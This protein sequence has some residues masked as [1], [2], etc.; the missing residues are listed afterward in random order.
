M[1]TEYMML[2][3]LYHTQTAAI[4]AWMDAPQD[5]YDDVIRQSIHWELDY[6]GLVPDAVTMFLGRNPEVGAEFLR[7]RY[8]AM[9]E[10]AYDTEECQGTR[11]FGVVVLYEEDEQDWEDE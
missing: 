8:D 6:E 10:V 1:Y 7:E 3:K 9:D 5:A 11:R 2:G 4:Q